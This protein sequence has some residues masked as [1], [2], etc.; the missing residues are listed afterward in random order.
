MDK[1]NT[2]KLVDGSLGHWYPPSVSDAVEP[3]AQWGRTS[4]CPA[5]DSSGQHDAEEIHPHHT[6]ASE[7]RDQAVEHRARVYMTSHASPL[8][9]ALGPGQRRRG[10]PPDAEAQRQRVAD[11]QPLG[12]APLH[13]AERTGAVGDARVQHATVVRVDVVLGGAVQQHVEMGA[14]VHVARLQGAREREHEGDVL[15]L[16]GVLADVLDVRR[17]AGGQAAGERGVGVDV[18]LEEV[19]E[20]VRHH[21]DRAVHLG[22]DAV[23]ELERFFGLVA[24]GEGDPFDLVVV[25][26]FDVLT[27]LTVARRA[28]WSLATVGVFGIGRRTAM[29][30]VTDARYPG[31]KVLTSSGSC[32]RR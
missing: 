26:V 4:Q 3:V 16:L 17:R 24:L 31:G 10:E 30:T 12:L 27:R 11:D 1:C 2:C 25:G 22:L 8:H 14:D 18:E 29:V 13:M 7:E 5:L 32:T 21:A 28:R 19:E 20:R 6:G 23:V 9:L 15:L